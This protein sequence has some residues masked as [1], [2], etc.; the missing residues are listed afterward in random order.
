MKTSDKLYTKTQLKERGWTEGLVA[1]LLPE[2]DQ[3]KP[4]PHHR[5]GPPM[6]LYRTDRVAEAEA[7]EA[8]QEATA[9]LANRRRA[10]MKGVSTKREKLKAN[11]ES[12][13]IKVPRLDERRLIKRACDHYNA[14][15]IDRG[16]MDLCASESS[17]RLFLERITVNYLRHELTPYEDELTNIAGQVGA[18]DA[19]MDIK[20]KV[21]DAIAEEYPWLAKECWRQEKRLWEDHE[22]MP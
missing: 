1:K 19:R 3:I 4:N 14:R 8:F 21:L 12:V 5:S 6:R 9:A 18:D 22:L 20:E 17:D 15:Q 7:C 16:N 10:A 13:E 2:P 11:L